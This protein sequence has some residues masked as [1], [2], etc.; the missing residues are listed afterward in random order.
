MYTLVGE[1]NELA[2]R[3]SQRHT[4]TVPRHKVFTIRAATARTFFVHTPHSVWGSL[5]G[6]L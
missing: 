5:S 6:V 4:G 1:K 3:E 2:D